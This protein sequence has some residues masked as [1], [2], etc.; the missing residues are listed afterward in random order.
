MALEPQVQLQQLSAVQPRGVQFGS[1]LC[2]LSQLQLSPLE[3]RVLFGQ[4]VL[5]QPVRISDPWTYR[6]PEVYGPYRWIRYY[7]DVLL[8]NTYTGEVVDVVHNFFY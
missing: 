6:L 3:R 4:R 8:V 1:V 2:A 5:W 7:D